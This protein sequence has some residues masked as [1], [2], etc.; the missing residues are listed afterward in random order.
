VAIQKSHPP[1]PG[2]VKPTPLRR[3]TPPAAGS[4]PPNPVQ[5]PRRPAPL[6]WAQRR[7]VPDFISDGGM[8]RIIISIE[9]HLP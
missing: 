5:S 7:F 2:P 6:A 4:P 8:D 9:I 1:S 3:P